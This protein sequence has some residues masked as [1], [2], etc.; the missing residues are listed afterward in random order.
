MVWSLDANSYPANNPI[1]AEVS[2]SKAFIVTD[3]YG[4]G[5]VY[6]TEGGE[7]QKL[8]NGELNV[9]HGIVVV[10]GVRCAKRDAITQLKEV[11]RKMESE[12]SKPVRSKRR[13]S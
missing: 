12:L 10:L 5:A 11:I 4:N 1:A 13:L 3:F 9:T 2:M 7:V 8:E 6:T